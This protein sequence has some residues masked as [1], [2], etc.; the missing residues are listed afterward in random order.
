MFKTLTKTLLM[1]FTVKGCDSNVEVLFTDCKVATNKT[2]NKYEFV[3]LNL[4]M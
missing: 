3:F 4:N 2:C 1:T